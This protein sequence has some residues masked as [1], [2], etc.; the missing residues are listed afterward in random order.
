MKD[1]G[2]VGSV[3][4]LVI[5][6]LYCALIVALLFVPLPA[7]NAKYFDGLVM[8]LV[9]QVA[10]VVGYYFGSSRSAERAATPSRPP[11]TVPLPKMPIPPGNDFHQ[12]DN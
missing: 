9:A 6:L 1:R 4:A 7:V 10:A 8:A 11:A 3:I 12:R 5:V 2:I